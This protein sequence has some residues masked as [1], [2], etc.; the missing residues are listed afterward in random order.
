M[1][2][3]AVQSMST[4]SGVNGEPLVGEARRG[5]YCAHL[6]SGEPAEP[7]Y[8]VFSIIKWSPCDGNTP[9]G[10]GFF[11]NAQG[12]FLT[13]RHVV[14]D[15]IDETG[16]IT[17]A[18]FIMQ[19]TNEGIIRPKVLRFYVSRM[20]DIAVG[21]AAQI[22]KVP[23]GIEI[24]NPRIQLRY[25]VPVEGECI[26]T[27]AYP[28]VKKTP[29]EIEELHFYPA[30]FAGVMGKNYPNGRDRVLMPGPCAETAMYVHGGASG[31]PVFNAQGEAFAVNSTGFE[32]SD[33]A[34]VTPV[35]QAVELLRLAGAFPPGNFK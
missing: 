35:S 21:I 33:T 17:H 9:I 14:E 19:L 26:H 25:S 8:A 10:T 2:G 23:T 1:A 22:E 16:G 3:Q 30:F 11:V 13:A 6:A 5:L 31:G 15:F 32:G 20:A 34:F 29:G 12:C 4:A 24:L 27:Y 28:K 18:V 7:T